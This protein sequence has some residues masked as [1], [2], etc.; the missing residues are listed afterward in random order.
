[1]DI[2]RKN[3]DFL[4][5]SFSMNFASGIETVPDTWQLRAWLRGFGGSISVIEPVAFLD[6]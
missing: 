1:M 2:N 4:F 3:M 6:T 5:K